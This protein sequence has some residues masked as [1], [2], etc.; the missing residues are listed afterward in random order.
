VKRSD[1]RPTPP[2]VERA[3]EVALLAVLDRALDATVAAI[4]AAHP[5]LADGEPYY[6]RLD[7]P[8]ARAADAILAR[9]A[10]L[11]DALH[12]YRRVLARLEDAESSTPGD[13]NDIPF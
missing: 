4:I 12:R 6:R 13:A 1:W 10:R 11:R 8:E 9:A 2:E 5:N 3:P 7:R